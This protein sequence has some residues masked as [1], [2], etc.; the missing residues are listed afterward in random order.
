MQR[1]APSFAHAARGVAAVELGLMMAP[2]LMLT[3]GV[4]EYGRAIYT[5][6]AVDK[7][8]RDATR[9]LTYALPSDPKAKAEAINLAVYG[10]IDGSGSPLASGLQASMVVICDATACPSTHANV[11]TGT[12]VMNLVTVSIT[13]YVY[14]SIVTYAAPS[15][16]NFGDIS[17]TMRAP[18]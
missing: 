3:F 5:Y 11:T 8:V 13:G 12:G 10:N 2:L 9:H 6:N 17:V 4:V 15:T 14:Q 1:N 16:M 7:A 18:L